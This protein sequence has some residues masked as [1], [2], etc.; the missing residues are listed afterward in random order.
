MEMI[1]YQKVLSSV[2]KMSLKLD[3]SLSEEKIG[4]CKL[5]P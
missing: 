4:K 5:K 1:Q 2:K 3:T